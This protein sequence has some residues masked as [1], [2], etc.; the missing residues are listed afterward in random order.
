MPPGEMIVMKLLGSD[1]GPQWI[2]R[3]LGKPDDSGVPDAQN[4][5]RE[6]QPPVLTHNNLSRNLDLRRPLLNQAV[7]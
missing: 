4:R 6:Q 5:R 2:D 7:D 1:E 3:N